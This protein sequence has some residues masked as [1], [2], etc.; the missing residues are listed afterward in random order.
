MFITVKRHEREKQELVVSN[1]LIDGML[2]YSDQGA[3][4]LD[5]N[6]KVLPQVSKSLADMFRR[7][8]FANLTFEKLLAPM[9]SAKTLTGVRSH[10]A[11]LLAETPEGATATPPQPLKDIEVRLTN[12]DGSSHTAHYWFDFDPMDGSEGKVWL[13]RV[14]DITLQV[15]TLRELEELRNQTQTQREILRGVLKMGGARFGKFL[16]K[17]DAS[18]KTINRVLKK[19]AREKDAFRSKLEETL[20]EVDRMRREAAAFKLTALETSA[21]AFEDALH[22]LRSRTELSGSD[23]LPLAVKL[24]QLFGQFALVKSLAL[25]AGP[26]ESEAS[27]QNSRITD[28]GT[29]IMEAPR[30]TAQVAAAAES[31]PAPGAEFAPRAA[32]VGVP[33]ASPPMP[34][35]GTHRTAAPT[36]SLDHTLQSLTDHVAHEQGKQVVLECHGLHAV[37]PRYQAAIKNVAIQFIRNAVMHGIEAPAQREAAGKSLHGVLRLEFK[38][39][40]DGFELSFEDDGCGLDPDQVRATAIARGVVTG[41]A[42]ERMRDRE[43]IK[44]IFKS[45]YTTLAASDTDLTHGSGMSLVRRYIHE[46]GGKIAL[47]SL[48]GHETRFKITL[49][50]V[51]EAAAGGSGLELSGEAERVA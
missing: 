11:G 5:G 39:L 50:P 48:A 16:H 49:P 37:P 12:P 6:D 19:S 10:I 33:T 30:F 1:R 2:K 24:D 45:R 44:L 13:V 35:S 43:A 41:E 17:A 20:E 4:L 29:Q 32:P 38:V 7:Q 22:D 31:A 23:F 27:L 15:Q 28:K 21:R 47:A 40:H 26:E 34:I 42:A 51:P 14:T 8:D 46:A 36:G 9:V 25:A 3:F 18:M